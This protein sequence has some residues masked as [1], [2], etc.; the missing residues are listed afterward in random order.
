LTN[1]FN[2]IQVITVMD[3]TGPVIACPADMTVSTDPNGCCAPVNLPDVI[4]TDNCSRINNV[5]ACVIGFDPFTGEQIGTFNVGGNV[6]TFPGNNIWN[7]DTLGAYGITPCLPIGTHTVKYFAEDD[8]GNISE[9]SFRLTVED[10]APPV[11]A[12]DEWTQVA[13][14]INGESFINATTFDDGSYDNCGPVYFRVRRMDANPCQSNSAF[15]NQVKF[16]CSDVGDTITVI[17]RVYD[18][19][20]GTNTVA[21]DAFEDHYNDCMVQVLVED[22]IKPICTSPANV[23][24]ACETFDPSLWAYGKATPSD[25]CCLDATKV[26]QGQIGLTHSVSLS[27]FDTTCNRGTITRTFRA[28]DCYG[29]SSQCTQRIVVNYN[30]N[31]WVKFP[32]DRIVTVCDGSANPFGQPEFFGKDC[33]LLAT[34]YA[35]EVFTVVLDACYK[36]ERTWT[37]INWCTYNTNQ[38]CTFVPNPSPSNNSDSPLNL[39]GVTVSPLGTT[40]ATWAPTVVAISPGAVPTNYS[41]FWSA[42]ANCY[43]YKQII[44][45]KDGQDPT[46]AA[47]PASPVEFC[48]ITPNENT[49]WNAMYWWDNVIGSH[50]LCEGPTD[51]SITATD[52]CSGANITINYQLFLD[53]DGNGS[54]ETVINSKQL[55]GVNRLVAGDTRQF[56]FRPVPFNQQYAFALQSTV[57]G[58]NRT[59]S[60]R[61]NTLQGPNTYTVPELPY[62]THKIKWTAEDGCGNESVCEYTFVVKDCKKPTVVCI[63]GLSSNV[64]PTGV[65]PTIWATDFL[66]YGS[67]NCTPAN[68]LK[69]SV[70]RSGTGTG[71]PVDGNGN[72]ITNISFS[73]ADLGTQF[74]ELWAID[75]AGNAD[76]CETYIIIQDNAG[77]CGGNASIAGAL[78]TEEVEGVESANVALAGT[79]NGAPLFNQVFSDLAGSFAFSNALPI[80][81]N[82]TVTPQHDVDPLNGVTTYDLLLISRHILGLEPLNT[83]YKQIAADANKSN[84]ITTFDIV[85][86]RKVILGINSELPN[87]QSWRF[88]DKS[89]VFTDPSNPF[90]DV[91]REN[92]S[93]AQIQSSQLDDDF[94]GVK[95]GDVNGS[96]TANSLMQSD[97][98][99]AGTLMFDVEDRAVKAG[100]EFTVNFKAADKVL[101]YQFTMNTNGLKVMDI[102]PGTDMTTDNFA[103]FADAITTSV[104]GSEGTFAVKFRASADGQLSQMLGVSS[105]ITKAQAYSPAASNLDVALRFNSGV[106]SGV[107]FELYQN[108]PNPFV[109]KTFVGF[110]LPAATE[111]TL[112]LFDE[113]GR[114]IYTQKGTYAKGYNAIAL[115]RS[116]VGS[117]GT[118]YYTLKTTTDTAT[119]KMIQTK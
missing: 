109:S 117:A 113:A 59:A 95:I 43:K 14:G 6:T 49:L 32:A 20:P 50:D 103:V 110:H 16:C 37:V 15:F 22:K 44:K 81:G 93:V 77:V 46:F 97:D 85:E 91:I 51:L 23:T 69:Y 98:R 84:T 83:P 29:N 7:P 105:R 34:S 104:D 96:A 5:R 53:L 58:V 55:P 66:L 75:K 39:P 90:A 108:A 119:K 68:Q 116:V 45:V 25:N 62:G 30:Q 114:V 57:T 19:D 26:Y 12:C 101:G 54:M 107:G 78:K 89:Q 106:V 33:E 60:V 61:W 63:N 48:D 102:V 4:I 99:T 21:I 18:V 115:D 24:V 74:V 28:F 1:P 86:L 82:Y 111:A 100:E 9:C 27:L 40:Q 8:C 87:N 76:F 118:L 36:I 13:L 64:G 80:G 35:D 72:P 67:D 92:I 3:N 70:R 88:V 56:D 41:T 94:V 73:C 65:C 10:L 112:T 79:A 47:C 2:Y 71:F 42:N 52:A 11:V 38:P 17:L 31:Y